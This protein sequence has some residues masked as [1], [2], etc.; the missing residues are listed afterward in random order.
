MNDDER[1][2]EIARLQAELD[3]EPG[4][5]SEGRAVWT[6]VTVGASIAAVIGALLAVQAFTDTGND[7]S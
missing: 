3:A 7:G 1:R 2:A 6:A 4:L 5:D